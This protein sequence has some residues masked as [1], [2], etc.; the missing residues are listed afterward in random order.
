ML[1]NM[2]LASAAAF[3]VLGSAA[4]L[5]NMKAVITS[6]NGADAA[7]TREAF[8]LNAQLRELHA[9]QARQST[10]LSV[11][12]STMRQLQR[13]LARA[14][15][16]LA[17]GAEDTAGE[18][19]TA[20]TIGLDLPSPARAAQAA[21]YHAAW[22]QAIDLEGELMAAQ[23]ALRDLESATE[24]RLAA[25]ERATET[26]IATLEKE[27]GFAVAR[28]AAEI[29]QRDSSIVGLMHRIVSQ[30]SGGAAAPPA[31]VRQATA[32]PP[33]KPAAATPAAATPAPL[34][35]ATPARESA[36]PLSP[37]PAG[38]DPAA[39]A[40]RGAAIQT[41]DAPG[42]GVG[43]GSGPDGAP[44]YATVADG[45]AAYHAGEYQQAFE[46]WRVLANAGDTRARFHLG[47]LYYE[48][49]GVARQLE[50]AQLLLGLAAADGHEGAAALRARVVADLADT[51]VAHMPADR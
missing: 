38:R 10:L 13:D 14:D 47:A 7:L 1:K 17:P 12:Q 6:G 15:K 42:G 27:H 50:T 20:W 3:V 30:Q 46:I 8:D 22:R 33:G 32:T 41:P 29:D 4:S 18:P 16:G 28:L 5:T 11:Q 45:A 26:R 24:E 48:G 25:L 44:S 34:R 2:L 19:E 40:G 23:N 35:P 51:E 9:E 37:P 21:D 49:R 36:A 31:S 39:E 43:T